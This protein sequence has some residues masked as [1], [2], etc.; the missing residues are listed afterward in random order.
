VNIGTTNSG[1]ERLNVRGP[2]HSGHGAANTRSLVSIG[3]TV[4]GN[5]SGLWIGSMITENTAVIGSRTATGNIAFQTYNGGWGE[6][7]RIRSDGNVGIG[8]ASPNQK[9][10]VGGDIRILDSRS[11]MFKRHGD[12]YAWRI[13]NESSSNSS[14]FGFD[15]TND[16]VFEVISNSNIQAT[17]SATSHNIYS[18]SVNTLVL[19]ETGKVGI[20]TQ[21]PT[22][23][24]DVVGTVKATAFQGDG[25][26]L[27]GLPAADNN[28]TVAWGQL[29]GH[30]TYTSFN[31]TPAY[32]GWSFVHSNSADCPDGS[33]SSQW[34]RQRV[35]LGSPYSK[36]A[37]GNSYWLE[38]AY[39]R[40]GSPHKQYQ[41]TCEA[42]NIGEWFQTGK[43]NFSATGGNISTAGTYTI[44]EFTSSG[45]FI[46]SGDVSVDILIVAGGAGG[47]TQVGGGGGAGGLIYK[48][49]Q[50]VSS[51][52]YN[53]TIGGG[54]S[55]GTAL[56]S[57]GPG[58]GGYGGNSSALGYTSIGG[59]GGGW[60]SGGNG[61]SGGSGGGAGG[62]ASP[63][64]G[65]SGQGNSGGNPRNGDWTGGGGGGAGARGQHGT[66]APGGWSGD[67]GAGLS[68]DISGVS[69]YYAGGGGGCNDQ[70]RNDTGSAGLGGGGH[71]TGNGYLPGSGTPNTGGGGGGQRD[72]H[73][74]GAGGSGVVIIRY[75]T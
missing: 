68:Y 70:N 5:T 14:T 53:I 65:T 42:G 57:G 20:G 32:W 9:L 55:P 73:A 30:G 2:G 75:L 4:S 43:T 44:H 21:T 11:L 36:G 34:Y 35:S 39:P 49:N 23:K 74:G 50:S 72:T 12:N 62:N 26:G 25:S 64:S 17:P 10:E 71:G 56:N 13:R 7:L 54:G 1:S 15:G 24:L 41:R 29:Q 59:G 37:D 61:R 51:G 69:K 33:V 63:G 58:P 8:D 66:E 22:Q 38:I 52:S 16:L 46:V 3:E 47:G 6:R 19:K 40:H 27:T 48:V 18:T 67:G 60:Y 31:S 45:S 28:S